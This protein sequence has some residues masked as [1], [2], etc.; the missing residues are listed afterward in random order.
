MKDEIINNIIS[1]LKTRG[2]KDDWLDLKNELN[3]MMKDVTVS[4]LETA[5]AIMDDEFNE[6][7]LKRFIVSK[8]VEGCTDKTVQAYLSML[9]RI[10]QQL[11]KRVDTI[12]TDDIR[13][14]LAIRQKRDGLSKVPCDNE[15][16]YMRTFFHYLQS[17]EIISKDPTAKIKRIKSEKIQKKAFSE[18]EVE[19]IRN[20]CRT[21]RETAIIEILL[22]TGCRVAELVG[23]KTSDIKNNELIVHGK[24]EK[25]RTVYLNAKAQLACEEY[26]KERRDD[27][28]YLFAG[29]I[30]SMLRSGKGI[31]SPKSPEW[32]KTPQ[33]VGNAN[34]NES[35]IESLCRK[36]GSIAG[37]ENCHPHRFRRTCATF[38]LRRGMPIE[39]VSKM[40]GHEQ[41]TTT[42]I[43]LDLG[44]EALQ[45]M[46]KKYVV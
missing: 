40:L 17:E 11:G 14:Y 6:K 15:L 35:T 45:Q 26:I 44:E 39:Q 27:N 5:L 36:L 2:L 46:H 30:R 33:Y 28:P 29:A 23:I 16:R 41:L 38:A 32:Y 3:L 7:C 12:E 42:Q 4:P 22:S 20:A 10:I 1:L 8:S 34:I 13:I 37:V 24:G 18:L 19:K 43:Y 9:R 25:D 31:P 21:K